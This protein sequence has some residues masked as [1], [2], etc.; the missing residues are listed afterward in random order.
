MPSPMLNLSVPASMVKPDGHG[1]GSA[2]PTGL[3]RDCMISRILAH[4][5]FG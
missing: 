3:Q 4:I 1:T 5:S 2:F